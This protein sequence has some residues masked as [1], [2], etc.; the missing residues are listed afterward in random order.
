MLTKTNWANLATYSR[1]LLIPAVI[2]CYLAAFPLANLWAAILFSIASLTDWL[3]GYLARKFGL[4]SKFGAFIDPVADKLLVSLVLIM[5]VSVY[6]ALMLATGVIIARELLVS[7]L[8][9]WIAG[10][11]ERGTVA[12]VFSG[13]LKT[14]V[15]MIAIIALLLAS[16]TGPQWIWL[17]GYFGLQLAALLSVY[18]MV[19]YF[20]SAWSTLRES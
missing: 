5:L 12:V 1:V 18:S 9:A 14:T 16:E 10:K 2:V 19:S 3:D 17:V 4:A 11:G 6:P 7:S 8:R 13:K 15:Q 20:K